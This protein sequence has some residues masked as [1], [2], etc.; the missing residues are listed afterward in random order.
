MKENNL[1]ARIRKRKFPPDYYKQKKSNLNSMPGNILARKFASNVPMK[2]LVTDIT[3][4]P[5]K[6]GWCY[7]NVILDLYNREVINYR[8]SKNLTVSLVVN[9]VKEIP[10]IANYR[11]AIFHSDQGFTYKHFLYKKLLLDNG[12]I[13]SMSRKGNCLDNA[14]MENF[15]GHLKSELY[16]SKKHSIKLKSFEEM[17]KIIDNYIV[18]YNN[19]R[20]QRKLGYISPVS[21]RKNAA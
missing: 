12:F 1:N 19:D 16:I 11:G 5:T 6:N 9:T 18:W 3:Y 10:N 2:K 15:F 14:S 17:K 20:I 7:L 21:F 8:I 4:L 13:Q